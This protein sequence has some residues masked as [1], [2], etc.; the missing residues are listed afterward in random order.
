MG[1]GRGKGFTSKVRTELAIAVVAITHWPAKVTATETSPTYSL[2][3]G[4]GAAKYT[5]TEISPSYETEVS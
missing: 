5:L 2:K 4:G 3:Y 1:F